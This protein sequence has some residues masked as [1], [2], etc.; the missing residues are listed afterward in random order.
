MKDIHTP[1][2][3]IFYS[4]ITAK[5]F[6]CYEAG[7]IPDNATT[8][9]V[10]ISSITNQENSN[11][12]DFGNNVQT[13]ID[14][15]TKYPR[16]QYAGSEEADNI[17]GQILSVINSKTKLPITSGLQIVNTKVL[18]DQK[19]N[20]RVDNFV[21]YRRLIRFENLIMEV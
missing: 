15:V 12:S 11:K 4:A 20:D 17:A 18:Q 13:L 16:T 7:A 8:P 14:I 10:V 9:Y 6:A 1:I 21:I 2:R 19:I 5:G 3:I